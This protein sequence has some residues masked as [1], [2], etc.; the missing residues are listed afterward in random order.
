MS[1]HE[2]VS[3]SEVVAVMRSER[4][5]MLTTNTAGGKL[6]A[7]PMTVQEVSDDADVWLFVDLESDH[8]DAL[9]VNPAVNLA[10]SGSGS[11][12]SVS[13]TIEF[14]NDRAK[15][16]ELWDGAVDAYFDGVD[17]PRL[18]L[19]RVDGDSAQFW[20]MPGGKPAVLAAMVKAKVTGNKPNG[21][22][23]TTEL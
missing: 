21:T 12:L 15:T 16:E 8:A 14:I 11:W 20:G 7:H 10:F 18:G 6:V 9:R 5:V 23:G 22:S 17:D 1:T 2:T 3:Q 13:G 19:I 4:I